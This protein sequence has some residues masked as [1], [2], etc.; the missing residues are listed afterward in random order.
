M[1]SSMASLVHPIL[2]TPKRMMPRSLAA[3]SILLPESPMRSTSLRPSPTVPLFTVGMIPFGPRKRAR[4][5]VTVG[6]MP[7][8]EKTR[9]GFSLPVRIGSHSS[10]CPTMTPGT[11]LARRSERL[12]D[13]AN[14]TRTSSRTPFRGSRGRTTCP[15][16]WWPCLGTLVMSSRS[17][18]D[19][20]A[21][22]SRARRTRTASLSLNFSLAGQGVNW[23]LRTSFFLP[24]EEEAEKARARA[25]PCARGTV[26]SGVESM[27]GWGVMEVCTRLLAL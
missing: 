13:S 12:S 8:V 10:C 9:V 19:V 7:G 6:S 17:K 22:I 25:G 5:A 2:A 26:R 4:L 1:F 20:G 15:R 16:R 14:T 11:S 3:Q 24:A 27:V 18:R 23:T 21:P